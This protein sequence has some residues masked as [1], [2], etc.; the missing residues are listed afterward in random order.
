MHE[1]QWT[2]FTGS[3]RFEMHNTLRPGGSAL[4][5]GLQESSLTLGTQRIRWMASSE[6]DRFEG[7]PPRSYIFDREAIHADMITMHT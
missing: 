5:D 4:C 7:V 1:E 2:M 3:G 6:F